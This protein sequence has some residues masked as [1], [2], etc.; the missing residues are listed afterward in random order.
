VPLAVFAHPQVIP[1]V[2]VTL[3]GGVP[4]AVLSVAALWVGVSGLAPMRA[5]RLAFAASALA[6]VVIFHWFA[7]ATVVYGGMAPWLGGLAPFVPAL[8]SACFTGLFAAAT[9]RLSVQRWTTPIAVALALTGAEQWRAVA[10]GGFPWASPGYA[11]WQNSALLALASLGGVHA[12]TFAIALAG[13]GLACVWRRGRIERPA[14]VAG[15]VCLAAWSL[16]AWLASGE[17]PGSGESI[18]VAAIQGNIDQREKWSEARAERNLARYLALSRRA[19]TAG[20]SLIVWPETAVPG[21]FEVDPRMR[22]PIEAL[23][24]ETGASFVVGGAGVAIAPGG[25]GD[26]LAAVYDSAFVIDGAG[27][28]RDRYDKTKLV[29]FGE[30]VPLRGVLGATFQALARGLSSRDLSPGGAPRTVDIPWVARS[31]GLRVGVPICY[32]LIFPDVVR[33]MSR[34]GAQLLLGI[35]NDAWYGRTGARPQ[36]LAITAVRAAENRTPLVRAANTGISA[37]VD[38]RGRVRK[39]SREDVQEVLVGDIPLLPRGGPGEGRTLYARHGDAFA[40][41][42]AASL[43]LSWIA[44]AR[45]QGAHRRQ[46][47]EDRENDCDE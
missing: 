18:R 1:R 43:L 45:N 7:V 33:R 13:A 31:E 36:F 9:S 11:A 8:F 41:V 37:I 22:E 21:F 32:E 30:F 16:G 35:T 17:R 3:D 12:M 25:E 34:D 24:R 44:S 6:Y 20:A 47:R 23:A 46:R 14:A 4:L 10:L 27:R 40:W 26:R 39:Q 2:G 28:L 38:A 15:G 42:C 5:F 29:P 19:A